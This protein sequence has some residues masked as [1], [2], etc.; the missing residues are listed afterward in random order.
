[1]RLFNTLLDTTCKFLAFIET[2]PGAADS[3]DAEPLYIKGQITIQNNGE[4]NP[5]GVETNAVILYLKD[6]NFSLST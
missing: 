6:T 4:E 1:M 5:S 3:D 2:C